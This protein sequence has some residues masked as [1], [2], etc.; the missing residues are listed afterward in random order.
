MFD[1]RDDARGREGGTAVREVHQDRDRDDR[2]LRDSLMRD[3]DLP[4]GDERELVMDRDRVFDLNGEDSRTLAAVGAFRVVPERDLDTDHDTVEHLRGEGLVETVDL[5]DGERGL[6]LT[7]EGRDLLDAHSLHRHDEPSQAFYSGVSRERELNHDSHLYSTYRQ[8]EARLRTEH[9]GL[10]VRRV[11][12]EQDLKRDTRSS[13][14]STTADVPIVTAAP[15]GRAR[16][17]GRGR[18]TTTCLGLRRAGPLPGLPHRIRGRRAR[19]A[20]G[21]RAVHTALPRGTR[22]RPQQG[23]I[24]DLRRW[25][26]VAVAGRA[27]RPRGAEEFL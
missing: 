6:T 15:T 8:E 18:A 4:R 25:V 7:R 26:A 20:P 1:P 27:P 5:G 13:C 3:L 9:D 14:R 24:P 11:V 22:R 16:D 23:R 21:R 17:P 10:E 19:T 2:D 12:L